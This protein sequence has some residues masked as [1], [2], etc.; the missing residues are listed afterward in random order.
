M[1]AEYKGTV[2]TEKEKEAVWEI[3]CECDR[4]FYPRLSL[5]NSSS[6]KDLKGNEAESTADNKPTVYYEEMIKQY[7]I[8]A[9]DGEEVVGFMTFKQDYTCE[10]LEDFGVSL[11][12][13]TVCVRKACRGQGIMKDLYRVMEQDVPGRCNCN[14]ISTRTWSLNDAQIHELTKRGYEKLAVLENDRGPGVDTVY[15]GIVM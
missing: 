7:F 13:T 6:Q 14:R 15:F 11:Y 9:Y 8:L 10:A 2:L 4:D 12:I 3:L 5:R 1:R